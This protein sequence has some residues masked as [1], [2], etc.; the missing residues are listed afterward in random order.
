MRTTSFRKRTSLCTN[1]GL[2]GH[3]YRQCT[4]PITSY[5]IIA[6]RNKAD[7]WD[8][9]S[10]EVLMIQRRDSIGF[11]ELLRAKYKLTDLEYIQQQLEGTTE[12]EREKMKTQSF[13]DLWVGLW[14]SS[15][16]ENKQ[17]K[18]E[19]DQASYKFTQLKTGYTH[20]GEEISLDTLL[21]KTPVQWSTPEW[22]FPK[23]RRN[24][25]ESDKACA[26][27][28]FQEETG[29][30][31]DKFTILD[32]IDPIRESFYGNNGI[33]YCHVYF[34]ALVNADTVVSYDAT[35]EH[36]KQEIGGLGW[37]T[38]Q[39][40]FQKIRTTNPEKRAILTR[41]DGILKKIIPVCLGDG[42]VFGWKK[43]SDELDRSLDGGQIG[44]V[45]YQQS[46]GSS[47]RTRRVWKSSITSTWFERSN[48]VNISTST[49]TT[50][51]SN[52]ST[53][54]SDEQGGAGGEQRGERGGERGGE[55]ER[56]GERGGEPGSLCEGPRSDSSSSGEQAS[57]SSSSSSSSS[58]SSSPSSEER[59]E[60]RGDDGEDTSNCNPWI[61]A[62]SRSTRKHKHLQRLEQSTTCEF[63]ED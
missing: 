15:P 18:Q 23:G 62:A 8:P 60:E 5:G 56:G 24:Q 34:L 48:S 55:P 54:T 59:G 9:S 51:D 22:G 31:E 38:V 61:T 21:T 37:F 52:I 17:Y 50:S 2:D 46:S 35:N 44:R 30:G 58:P 47:R 63:L 20:E 4:A 11:I 28:E 41:A 32:T 12:D 1:C 36:M 43:K 27:R 6:V 49:S 26:C 13:H 45:L 7:V 25:F 10:L 29:L 19:F 40:A 53:S 42:A 39:E 16:K 14:G 3:Q 57:P 33:H